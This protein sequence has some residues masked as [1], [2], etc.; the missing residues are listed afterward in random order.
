MGYLDTLDNEEQPGKQGSFCQKQLNKRYIHV[1]QLSVPVAFT[2]MVSFKAQIDQNPDL[3]EQSFLK[4]YTTAWS[5]ALY[6]Y[7]CKPVKI[8]SLY[9]YNPNKLWIFLLQMFF[10]QRHWCCLSSS[11]WHSKTHDSKNI[12]PSDAVPCRTWWAVGKYLVEDIFS[13][14]IAVHFVFTDEARCRCKWAWD[15]SYS[16]YNHWDGHKW[17]LLTTIR[18]FTYRDTGWSAPPL[19]LVLKYQ[20]FV[21][22]CAV[23][24]LVYQ[25]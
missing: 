10:C 8:S 1:R 6:F 19:P 5:W 24:S 18:Y 25:A 23:A 14:G 2:S 21:C 17:Q 9:F 20:C 15:K 12:K 11:P 3:Y 4:L 16:E 13:Y 22:N 7:W